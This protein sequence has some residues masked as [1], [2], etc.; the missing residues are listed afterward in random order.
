MEN[1]NYFDYWTVQD[2]RVLDIVN[3]QGAYYPTI[4]NS[5]FLNTYK[6]DVWREQIKRLYNITCS[7]L[8]LANDYIPSEIQGVVFAFARW[9]KEYQ[10]IAQIVNYGDFYQFININIDKLYTYWEKAASNPNNV[11]LRLRLPLSFN[12]VAIDFNG[13]SFL[14]PPTDNDDNTRILRARIERNLLKGL[15]Q[16]T[17]ILGDVDE[18]ALQCHLPGIF[19]KDLVGV[20]PMFHMGTNIYKDPNKSYEDYLNFIAK[21]VHKHGIRESE[22]PMKDYEA[23]ENMRYMNIQNSLNQLNEMFGNNSNQN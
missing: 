8:A 17:K 19:K 22:F 1:S 9:N 15:N 16:Y 10:A 13:W 18:D 21:S 7:G 14:M 12:S 20:Y 3:S 11:I 6:N 5:T 23:M 4:E 2:K